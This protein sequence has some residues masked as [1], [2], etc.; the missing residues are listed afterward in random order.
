MTVDPLYL[1]VTIILRGFCL[2]YSIKNSFADIQ[3]VRPEL[4]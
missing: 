2:D 4:L 1:V 3:F